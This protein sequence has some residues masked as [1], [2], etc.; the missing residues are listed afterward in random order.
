MKSTEKSEDVRI[1]N[2]DQMQDGG[3]P[4]ALE[5]EEQMNL[6]A[7]LAVAVSRIEHEKCG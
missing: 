1:E 7:Y 4:T 3:P 2:A 5:D 6:Q